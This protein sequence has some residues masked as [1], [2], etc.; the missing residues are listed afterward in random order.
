MDQARAEALALSTKAKFVHVCTNGGDGTPDVRIVFNLKRKS[1]AGSLPKAF[2]AM[3]DGFATYIGTN[4]SSRKTAQALAD[5]RCAIYY[6]D[7]V[8]FQGLTVYGRLEPVDD[9]AERAALWKKGWEVYYEGGLGGGDFQVF[10]F[11]PA[12]ARYYRGLK[13]TEFSELP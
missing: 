2:S 3:K 12:R 4:A 6:E 1:R 10:R 9:G 7:T 8:T 5:P 11:V 13:V